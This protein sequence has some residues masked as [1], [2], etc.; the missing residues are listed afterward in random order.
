MAEIVNL[1][2][3]RKE[4]ARRERTQTAETNRLKFGRPKAEAE[5][6]RLEAD[7]AR[8]NHEGHRRDKDTDS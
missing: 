6:D 4:K 8:R 2:G 3:V 7:R 1:R 5:H